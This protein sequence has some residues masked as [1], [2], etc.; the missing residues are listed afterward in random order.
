MGA[1]ICSQTSNYTAS[2]H[3][4]A[5]PLDVWKGGKEGA[6]EGQSVKIKGDSDVLLGRRSSDLTSI[7]IAVTD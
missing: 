5:P 2:G 7:H 3:L 4:E 6:A 1:A